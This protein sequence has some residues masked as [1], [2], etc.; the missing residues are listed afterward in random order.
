M[1]DTF[2]PQTLAADLS[3]VRR[4]YADFFRSLTEAD[5]ERTVKGSPKE[6]DLHETVAHLCALNGAGLESIKHTLRG[7]PY[8]FTGLDNR[9]VFT[10]YNRRG[11]DE[12]RDIPM[13]AL[14]AEL[15]DILDEAA[16][17]AQNLQP[18]Q[19]D[20]A[21]KMPIYNRPVKIT[22]A[23]GII[24]IHA[25]VFHTAQVTEPAGVPPL[26]IRLSPDIRHRAIGRTMRALS[27]L[28]RYDLGGSLKAVWAFRVDG[29]GGGNW[30]IDVAPG[31]TSS[32]AGEVDHASL[33][34]HLRE[35]GVFCRM[36]TGRLNLPVALLTRQMKLSGDL[37]LFLRMS[38]LFSVDA[39]PRAGAKAKH[40]L[41]HTT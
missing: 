30:H 18:G 27:L 10:A 5:W 28:Y 38:S 6:W 33:T 32:S 31:T 19:A 2:N 23:L 16:S 22:E 29:P 9:Y 25:G 37:R 1:D 7:E 34:I 13:Q 17:I 39:R 8:T 20:I 41:M 40:P 4:L 15:L 26:W 21:I 14:C 11:I 12:H 35:T 36:F 3:E 24:M